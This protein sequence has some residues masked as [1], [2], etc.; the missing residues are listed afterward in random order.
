MAPRS[1]SVSAAAGTA[2]NGQTAREEGRGVGRADQGGGAMTNRPKVQRAKLAYENQEFLESWHGRGL[3]ILSE[4]FE[5][6]GRFSR[7]KIRDTIVFFGSARIEETGPMARYYHDAR[8][9]AS[10]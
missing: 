1:D 3:R 9:L 4:Y 5:P 10:L 7:A 6:L 8:E 2:E